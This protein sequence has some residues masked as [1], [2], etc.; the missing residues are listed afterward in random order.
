MNE[1]EDRDQIARELMYN[2]RF[3]PHHE[4]LTKAQHIL[5]NL[6]EIQCG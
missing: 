4:A 2:D 6:Q 3:L 1:F 5:D